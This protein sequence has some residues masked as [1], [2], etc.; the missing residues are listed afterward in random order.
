MLRK[1]LVVTGS[2]SQSLLIFVE[3][4]GSALIFYA[5]AQ[6]ANNQDATRNLISVDDF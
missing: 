3:D 4:R 6:K 1:C 5:N 2:P